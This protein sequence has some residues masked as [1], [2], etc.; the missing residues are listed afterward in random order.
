[1][2]ERFPV[3]PDTVT[4]LGSHWTGTDA[5]WRGLAFSRATLKTTSIWGNDLHLDVPFCHPDDQYDGWED[6]DDCWARVRP[7]AEPGRRWRRRMVRTVEIVPAPQLD[8]P[9]EIVVEFA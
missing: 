5:A 6:D 9:W 4:V 1:M 8:P 7:L 2:P 3:T